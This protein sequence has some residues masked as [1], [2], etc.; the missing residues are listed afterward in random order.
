MRALG[1]PVAA[2]VTAPSYLEL[3]TRDDSTGG[4]TYRRY[5]TAHYL[6]QFPTAAIEAFLLRGG[7]DLHAGTH[8]PGVGLQAHGGAIA[9]V[10][11]ADAAFSHRG[12]MFEF[13]AGARW[14]DPAEDAARMAAARAADLRSTRTP[15]ASTSTRS[16]PTTGSAA[17]AGPTRPPSWPG[18]PR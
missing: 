18:W 6:G 3:Q 10:P 2:R 16:T 12:T 15:A 14:T 4:H 1:R 11:D 17:S 13:G 8:L 5:S 9:D 7:T